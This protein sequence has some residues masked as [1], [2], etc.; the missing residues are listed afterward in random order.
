MAIVKDASTYTDGDGVCPECSAWRKPVNTSM[1]E[2]NSGDNRQDASMGYPGPMTEGVA[3]YDS[4]FRIFWRGRWLILVC[5]VLA[6]GGAGLY[7]YMATPQYQSTS[8]I[9]VDKPGPQTRSDVPQ[10]VGSTSNN[11]LQTQA[12]MI[13]S[14]EIVAAALRDPN[15][16]T[17]PTLRGIGSPVGEVIRSLA[18][19]VGKNSDIVSVTAK[20]VYPDDAAQIV[21]AVVRAYQRWH[22]TNKQ[23]STADLLGSLN[24]QL[25]KRYQ[26]LRTK[27]QERMMFEQRNL[28]AVENGERT[29]GSKTLDLL[30]EDLAAA[31]VNTIEQDTFY[32]GI[33]QF[34]SEPNKLRQYVFSHHGGARIPADDQERV[35]L[36]NE[37]FATKLHLEQL[38]SVGVSMQ[39]KTFLESR[40]TKLQEQIDQ[41]DKDFVQNQ[42]AVA[43]AFVENAHEREKQLQAAYDRELEEIQKLSGQNAEYVFILAECE[44]IESLCDS[45]LKQINAL[46]VN[47]SLAGLKIHVLEK[48]M[49]ALRPSSPKPFRVLPLG[50]MLGLLAGVGLALVRDW[51]DQRVRSADEITSLLGVPVLGAVPSIPR[52]SLATRNYLLAAPNSGDAEAYRVI[53]TAL[54]FGL[55]RDEART[56]LVTSPAPLEGKTTLVTNLGIAMARAGQKTLILD[57]DLRR[58][59]Q[60]RAFAMNGHKIGLADVLNGT[61]ALEQAIRHTVIPGLDVLAS[62]EAVENPSELLS[63]SLF[64]GLL[65]GI[66]RKYDR[67]L[68]D[69]PPIGIAADAQVLAALCDLT[70][71]VLRAD[72]STRGITQHA[73]DLLLTVGARV[74][75]VVVNDVSAK[76]SRYT[77]YS[78]YGPYAGHYGPESGQAARKKSP[79]SAEGTATPEKSQ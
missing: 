21:N 70:L 30:K 58:P 76:D 13:T 17:L 12:S 1:R 54:F 57:A 2:F 41:I 25:E 20:S 24:A 55:P 10:P 78:T 71:L 7:L 52:R 43:K 75:G 4:L 32:A 46:D 14:R 27:R 9:L 48:A 49:P 64:A 8:R 6:L 47:A 62:K 38:T 5:T 61:A 50:L 60:H 23:L 79:A 45:L 53:R 39:Q 33:Q 65:E 34:A 3:G 68:V 15:V 22:E 67:V 56:V 19:S 63:S 37:L 36:E 77:S 72:H 29:F 18:V 59:M 66:T 35:R 40:L 44:T 69:S 26:E 16:L 11:Y 31:H 42:I 74:A 28:K 73:R 51:R